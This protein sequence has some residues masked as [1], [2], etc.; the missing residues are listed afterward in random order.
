VKSQWLGLLI[1]FIIGI[2]VGIAIN[3]FFIG[4]PR[5]ADLLSDG[6]SFDGD[7]K[8]DS[9]A[10]LL[11]AIS[12]LSMRIEELNEA[13]WGYRTKEAQAQSDVERIPLRPEKV[14]LLAEKIEQLVNAVRLSVSSS[15]KN[16]VLHENY[17]RLRN[18][19]PTPV[20]HQWQTNSEAKS[21]LFLMTYSQVL[22]RCGPPQQI[23]GGGSV[24]TWVYSNCY[25]LFV[26]GYVSRVE[27]H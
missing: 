4:R 6:F 23:N 3:T 14:D 8:A 12:N 10:A 17:S 16:T 19:T 18:K 5:N 24:V 9:H 13:T 22:A 15:E 27:L 21:E 11:Q 25:V 7:E 26:D 2:V 1:M 20:A